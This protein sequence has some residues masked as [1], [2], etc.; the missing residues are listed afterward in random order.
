MHNAKG[1]ALIP[2]LVALQVLALVYIGVLE[3]WLLDSKALQQMQSYI[4]RQADAQQC[5]QQAI[6][7]LPQQT[8]CLSTQRRIQ[9]E[10]SIL[11]QYWELE[12]AA[13]AMR[14]FVRCTADC[15][16]KTILGWQ[17]GGSLF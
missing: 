5:M 11:E 12:I 15:T 2:M 16:Q 3:G 13:P 1:F 17:T 10:P 8:A 6:A 4:Q 14:V 7:A 9:M